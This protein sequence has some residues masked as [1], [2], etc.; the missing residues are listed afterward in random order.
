MFK[1]DLHTHILP[2]PGRWPDWTKRSGYAGWI[3]LGRVGATDGPAGDGAL[4]Q[5]GCA[6]ARMQRTEPDGSRTFFRQIDANCWDPAARLRDMSRTRVGAQVLSTVPVLFSY[7]ARP[8]HGLDVSRWLN[9]HLAE[10]CRADP[11]RFVGLGTIPMQD[12]ALAIRE[13]ER[14]VRELGFPGV[15]IGTNVNGLNLDDPGIVEV[16]AACERLDAC[17]FV[18]PW[19]MVQFGRHRSSHAPESP[20]HVDRMARHWMPWLVGMPAETCIAVCSLLMGGVLERLPKLRICFAHGGGSFP[21]TLGRIEHGFFA[22]P[23]LCQT[24]TPTPPSAFLAKALPDGQHQPAAFFVDSLTHDPYAVRTLIRL[25]GAERVAL[26][27]DY[28]FPLGEEV[29][30]EMI[31]SIRDLPKSDL[32]AL[33]FGTAMAFLG[34]SN[35]GDLRRLAGSA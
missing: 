30:G 27:S 2:P 16:L 23:D 11:A 29:P 28:P 26:G 15:Q 7:W 17:V 12:P 14:C 13:L 31:E 24:R 5:A 34:Q 3:E 32:R 20:T 1:I 8:Q 22:R 4:A 10:V 6:C 19:E 35:T 33:L 25:F 21:F 18:H 9:D